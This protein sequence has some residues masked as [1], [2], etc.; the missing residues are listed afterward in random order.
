MTGNDIKNLVDSLGITVQTLAELLGTADSTVYRW[1]TC[2]ESDVK[3]DLMQKKILLLL[4]EETREDDD[5]LEFG[6]IITNQVMVRGGLY[7]LYKLLNLKF[8]G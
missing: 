8:G 6:R 4:I 1:Q 2:K 5:K 7:A 3:V